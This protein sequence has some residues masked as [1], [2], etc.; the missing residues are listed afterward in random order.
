MRSNLQPAG[1]MRLNLVYQCLR[2]RLGFFFHL[3]VL[4]STSRWRQSPDFIVIGAQ[5]AG[6]SSLLGGLTKLPGVKPPWRKEVHFFDHHYEKGLPWYLSWFPLRGPGMT[7]EASPYYMNHPLVAE[8]IRESLGEIPLVAILRHPIDRAFSHYRHNCRVGGSERE[9]ASFLEALHLEKKR[10]EGEED[11]LVNGKTNWSP[12]HTFYSYQTRGH[13]LKQ[14]K[15]FEP[16]YRAGRLL[17]IWFEELVAEPDRVLAEVAA[18]IGI[19]QGQS[20][21][22]PHLNRGS[23]KEP[24]PEPEA[25]RILLDAFQQPNEDLFT[26]LGRDCPAW[27]ARDEVYKRSIDL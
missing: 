9:P 4:R 11:A 1:A 25:I 27:R 22:L 13:Y 24:L 20:A 6:T 10:L 21:I 3:L 18:H 26:W 19:D 7:G 8:R 2:R 12:S 15:R 5:K 23:A 17:V 16:E 14:L